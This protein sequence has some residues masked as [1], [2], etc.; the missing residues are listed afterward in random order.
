MTTASFDVYNIETALPVIDL[1][2]IE[3][4]LRA[5]KEQE[6]RVSLRLDIKIYHKLHFSFHYTSMSVWEGRKTK[7]VEQNEENPG[8]TKFKV[9]VRIEI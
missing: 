5:A 1:E 6:R 4:H 9:K 7:V 3:N 8:S 2:A